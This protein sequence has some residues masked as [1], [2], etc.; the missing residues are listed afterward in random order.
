VLLATA[1][2]GR[3]APLL[4]PVRL[5]A[6]LRRLEPGK[7]AEPQAFDELAEGMQEIAPA[8][9]MLRA[10]LAREA[11]QNES[12]ARILSTLLVRRPNYR[13]ARLALDAIRGVEVDG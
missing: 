7:P 4:P 6:A 13:P 11:G 1:E 9:W 3:R 8:L 5:Y 10:Q 2:L 12:A